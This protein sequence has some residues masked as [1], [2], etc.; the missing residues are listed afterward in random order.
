MSS[1]VTRASNATKRPGLAIK[2][3]PRRTSEEV[4]AA[5]NTKKAANAAKKQ[6]QEARIKRVAAFESNARDNEDLIDATPRPNFTPRDSHPDS[7]TGLGTSE[8]DGPNPNKNTYIPPDESDDESDNSVQSA[9][10]MPVPKRK[11]KATP[12]AAASKVTKPGMAGK[13]SSTATKQLATITEN[14]DSDSEPLAPKK[15]QMSSRWGQIEEETDSDG[16]NLP[17]KRWKPKVRGRATETEGSA[18]VESDMEAPPSK[19]PKVVQQSMEKMG[20]KKES[21]REAIAAI[22]QGQMG[23]NGGVREKRQAEVAVGEK[24][25]AAV[26]EMKNPLKGVPKRFGDG[27]QWNRR[28]EGSETE[29]V[30][31]LEGDQSITNCPVKRP[32]QNDHIDLPGN[33]TTYVTTPLS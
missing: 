3:A 5:A 13:A 20:K 16:V 28:G 17:L 11:K 1:R 8:D 10:V 23:N 18:A 15:A 29:D 4:K 32:N 33:D 12:A 30:E 2:P 25:R 21:V 7:E 24:A 14:S 19:K 26:T 22:Q 9:E 31:K 27:P 6:A